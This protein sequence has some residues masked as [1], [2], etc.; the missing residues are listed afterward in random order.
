MR[1]LLLV[2][3]FT[4][5]CSLHAQEKCSFGGEKA[6]DDLMTALEKA[7]SCRAAAD[8]LHRCEWGSSADTQ[9]A[10]VV[11]SK[12]EKAFLPKLP[13]P[14]EERYIQEMQ[15]CAY[16]ESRAEGTLS[17][18]EAA[19][20]QVDVAADYATRPEKKNDHP[21]RASF[22]CASARTSF[23]TA[24]CSH[25]ALGNADIVLSRIYSG[26][27]KIATSKERSAV[28]QNQKDW[29]AMVP[30]KCGLNTSPISDR[31]I[32]CARNEFELRFS[33]LDDCE[34]NTPDDEANMVSC[35]VASSKSW[36]DTPDY[37]PRASFDCEKPSDGVELAICADSDLGQLDLNLAA[38][39]SDTQTLLPTS[40]HDALAASQQQWHKFVA[41]TCPLGVVGGIPHVIARACIRDLYQKRIAQLQSCSRKESS[42]ALSCLNHFQGP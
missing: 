42:E 28:V 15:L 18:S 16:E 36:A 11:I 14:A 20:C 40:D 3:L 1:L 35:I 5:A 38:V 6:F 33:T 2:L 25:I 37:S 29:L 17:M 23:E 34:G 4:L 32:N 31:S 12:C 39:Y 41:G 10:P 13:P 19:M 24:T 26:V 9:F 27:L 22:D 8:K 7:P 21:L 30:R